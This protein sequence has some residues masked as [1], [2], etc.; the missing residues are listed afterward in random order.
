M[1]FGITAD[2]AGFALRDPIAL[3]LRAL[4]R[5]TMDFGVT[6][7]LIEGSCV[8]SIAT[9]ARA[10]AQGEVDRGIAIRQ[11]GVGASIVTNKVRGVRA[12]VCHDT[13]S[14]RHGVE[15]K[16]LNLLVL[17]AHVAVAGH[18]SRSLFSSPRRTLRTTPCVFVVWRNSNDWNCQPAV[19]S[20]LKP[21]QQYESIEQTGGAGPCG[22]AG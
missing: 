11:R 18:G 19:P 15:E 13:S 6:V 20:Q 12:G 7:P 17:G 21:E 4:G 8:E 2:H 1:L 22:V 9:L 16:S 14:A 5:E 10:V 3:Q